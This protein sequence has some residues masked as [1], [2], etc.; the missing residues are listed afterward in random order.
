MASFSP[1]VI[2]LVVSRGGS[3]LAAVLRGIGLAIVAV[4]VVFI[5]LT[6]LD[7]NPSNAFASFIAYLADVFDLGLSDLFL[8]DNAKLRVTLNYG[9]A[10]VIWLVITSIVSRL[11]SR[12]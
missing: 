1:E 12:A 5:L 7:A 4:L 11:A 10:A 9:M 3:V 8:P 6:L 2:A